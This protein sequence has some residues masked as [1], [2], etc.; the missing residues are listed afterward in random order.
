[1]RHVHQ[2]LVKFRCQI[3]G[4]GYHDS[5]NYHDH[6]ATHAGVKRNVCTICKAQFTFVHSLS[7]HVLRFHPDAI[8]SL[9][10]SELCDARSENFKSDGEVDIIS[11]TGG[12]SNVW[13]HTH[14]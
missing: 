13:T 12:G 4:K 3:C 2:K 11:S 9:S 7:V 6:M 14:V 10:H 1:M 8:E 5:R